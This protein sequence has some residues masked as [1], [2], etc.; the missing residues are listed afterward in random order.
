MFTRSLSKKGTDRFV[1]ANGAARKQAP[2]SNRGVLSIGGAHEK[3]RTRTL[4][5]NPLYRTEAQHLRLEDHE[6]EYQRYLRS[7]RRWHP[8]DASTRMLE[9]GTGTGWFPLLCK[10]DGLSCKG[11]EIS[12]QLVEYARQF[13]RSHGIESDI[14]LGNAEE[15]EIGAEE[16]DV[17]FAQSVFEHIE[18]WERA[19][20]RIYRRAAAGRFVYLLLDQ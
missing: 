11:L 1:H 18:H 4:G 5:R 15:N 16:Y 12:P 3:L 8:L 13:G 19:A 20:E 9:I 17:I 6:A 10:R 7:V 2:G 14:E